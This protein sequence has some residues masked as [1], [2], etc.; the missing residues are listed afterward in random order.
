MRIQIEPRLPTEPDWLRHLTR[1]WVSIAG[2]VNGITEG[3]IDF[4]HAAVTAAP[5]T[6]EYKQ[7]DRLKNSAPAELGGAGSKYVIEGWV[8]VASGSPGTWKEQ[9][10]LTGN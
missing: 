9:R 3:R 6:G 2:Q 5:T 4:N 1:L 10:T 8:C 7:G